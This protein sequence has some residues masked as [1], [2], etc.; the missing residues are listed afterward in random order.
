MLLF[1]HC[2]QPPRTNSPHF[3]R[4]AED[5][6]VEGD[7]DSATLRPNRFKPKAGSRDRLRERLQ[8]ALENE[9][10]EDDSDGSV[11]QISTLHISIIS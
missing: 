4:T 8:E 9:K 3:F 6:A 2:L 7:E 10:D 5:T 11:S 1:F